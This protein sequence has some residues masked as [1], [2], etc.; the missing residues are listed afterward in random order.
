[1]ERFK[2]CYFKPGHLLALLLGIFAAILGG[3]MAMAGIGLDDVGR[4]TA[5]PDGTG[6]AVKSDPNEGTPPGGRDPG[7]SP[8]GS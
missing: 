2:S 3:G 1:M 6:D 8:Q 5:D 7:Q 4:T